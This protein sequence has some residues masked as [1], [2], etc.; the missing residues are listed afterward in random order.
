MKRYL[1]LIFFAIF[2]LMIQGGICLAA[3]PRA[4][5]VLS[6]VGSINPGLAEFILSGIQEAENQKAEALVIKLDTPGGLDIS[7]RQIVQA[8][9]NSKVPV[10][11][12]VSPSGARAASAG[13]FITEAAQVAAMAP[14]T[15]IGAAH[16]VSIGMGQMDKTMEN[17]VLNDFVAYGRAITEERRRNPDWMEKAIRQSV[18]ISAS[19]ALKLKVVDLLADN[20]DDLLHKVNG[21]RVIVHGQP[22]VLKTA[23]A[24]VKEIQETLRTRLLRYIGDPNIAFILMMIGLAGIY[25]ELAHPGVV[26]PG[27]IGSLCLLLAL[28]AFQTLPVNYIGVLLILLAFVF[29]ILEFKIT[30]YGLLSLAGVA[31]L[32]LGAIMLFRGAGG[33][34]EISWAVLIPTVLTVSLFFIVVAGIVFRSHFQRAMT[35]TA[36]MVGERGVAVTSL[37]PEGRVFVHGEYWLAVSDEPIGAK[38][39]IEI[40][41]VKNLQLRVRR[42]PNKS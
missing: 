9:S 27:V 2:T 42:A 33:G 7:M 30:S 22:W 11:V 18:S 12:Y 8:I 28:F 31:S 19:E 10:I 39:P 26:L 13:V 36:G 41:E 17:K 1:W 38:E 3:E 24:P 35:G 37:S 15:N 25:F 14:G 34:M 4:V 23:G 20:L 16:P 21:R 5:F 6:A 40:L 29:F 32:F